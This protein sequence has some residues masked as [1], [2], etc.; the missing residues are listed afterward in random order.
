M[1]KCLGVRY[2]TIFRREA[3]SIP[4]RSKQHV[5]RTESSGKMVVG[6]EKRGSGE[7]GF[8]VSAGQS[9]SKQSA[10]NEGDSGSWRWT[11]DG[12]V[13]RSDNA[14]VLSFKVPS[15]LCNYCLQC[16]TLRYVK[17]GKGNRDGRLAK[18]P[19]AHTHSRSRTCRKQDTHTPSQAKT[20]APARSLVITP[21]RYGESLLR[22]VH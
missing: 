7:K 14:R 20:S 18:K 13:A 5:G 11:A 12:A 3:N 16:V 19:H 17:C 4:A 15:S 10:N 22:R 2:W 1:V 9:L 8:A 6:E 21:R